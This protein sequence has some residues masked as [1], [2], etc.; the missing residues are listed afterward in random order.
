MDE[1]QSLELLDASAQRRESPEIRHHVDGDWFVADRLEKSAQPAVLLVGERQDDV[2]HLVGV[3]DGAQ[4]GEAADRVGAGHRERDGYHHAQEDDAHD[5]ERAAAGAQPLGGFAEDVAGK[6]YRHDREDP[7][8][9]D[10]HARVVVLAEE[11]GHHADENEGAHS[12]GLRDVGHLRQARP[13][14]ARAVEVEAAEGDAPDDED[15]YE[16][17]QVRLEERDAVDGGRPGDVEAHVIREEPGAGDQQEIAREHHLLEEP[18]ARPQHGLRSARREARYRSIR[19]LKSGRAKA[20]ARRRRALGS[21][22]KD[23]DSKRRMAATRSP[24]FC[25]SKKMPVAGSLPPG[26]TTVSS[27]PPSP[28]AITGRPEAIASSGVMPKSSTVGKISARQRAYS[29]AVSAS[30]RHPSSSIVGPA[31]ARSLASSGPVPTTASR[32]PRRLAASTARS[33]RLYGVSAETTR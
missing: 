33:T 4:V 29:S 8:V 7:E 11:E 19:S 13:D 31:M 2:I 18:R 24:A 27:A 16:H 1:G 23:P 3:E 17:Q 9:D 20:S 14:A 26:G 5:K 15:G 12:R 22:R 10:D 21:K 30:S 32:R 25:R 28:S 6:G